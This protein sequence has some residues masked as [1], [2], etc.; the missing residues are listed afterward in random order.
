[1]QGSKVALADDKKNGNSDDGLDDC[2]V[3]AVTV[4]QNEESSP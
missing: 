1:M 2:I 3:G 4:H